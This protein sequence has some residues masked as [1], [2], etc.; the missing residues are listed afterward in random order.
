[1]V[2]VRNFSRKVPDTLKSFY[3]KVFEG[4]REGELFSKSAGTPRRAN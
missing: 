3:I 4:E 2:F 1:M